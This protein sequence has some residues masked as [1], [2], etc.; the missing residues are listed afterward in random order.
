[1]MFRALAWHLMGGV[2]SIIPL[3]HALMPNIQVRESESS[4]KPYGISDTRGGRWHACAEV[5]ALAAPLLCS[6][7]P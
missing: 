3:P 7:A 6:I 5:Q 1:M 4:R 2:D